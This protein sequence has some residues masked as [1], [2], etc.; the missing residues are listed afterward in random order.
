MSQQML[1]QLN[2][3]RT[4]LQTDAKAL[5]AEMERK[6]AENPAAYTAGEYT[7]KLD[8]MT[9]DGQALTDQIVSLKKLMEM[10]VF[11]EQQGSDGPSEGGRQID[12][13]SN[14]PH[15]FKSWG[16]SFV[17]SPQY[18]TMVQNGL[19]RSQPHNVKAQ[20]VGSGSDVSGTDG[21][22]GGHLVV[23]DRM[24][25]VFDKAPLRPRRV[26]DIIGKNT[27]N[28]DRVEYAVI[29]TKTNNAA[30]VPERNAG[31]TDFGT[32]P[33][34]ELKFDLVEET[35]R[36]VAHWIPVSR[37]A[38][39][40]APQLRGLI[41]TFLGDGLELK[42]EDLLISGTGTNEIKGILNYAIQERVH[43]SS[44]RGF[45]A[46]DNIIDSLRRAITDINVSF[47]RAD[48]ILL[49]PYQAE[50][51]DLLKDEDKNYMTVFDPL[52]QR[53]L[54]LPVVE[55]QALSDGTAIVGNFAQ[56]CMFWDRLMT[57]IRIGE[58]NDFFIKNAVAVLAELRCAFGVIWEDMFEKVTGLP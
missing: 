4:K 43:A 22:Y 14:R 30:T 32:K 20:Y 48:T 35:V 46:N 51:I 28:S 40:D 5:V 11:Q 34:S 53:L 41:N 52:Q 15:S 9:A 47:Y 57:E 56:G 12:T 23:V 1:A 44:G 24:R 25:Q 10:E 58:P 8:K 17:E 55:T 29:T 16:Q 26:L 39:Q 3:R 27:T 45:S 7:E 18:K 38:L 50:T 37:Q 2:E 6:Y 36:T 54:R 33:Q 21:E 49:H 19:D 13:R 31:G 42:V